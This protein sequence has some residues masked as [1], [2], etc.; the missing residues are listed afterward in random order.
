MYNNRRFQMFSCRFEEYPF[1]TNKNLP[2]VTSRRT[3]IIVIAFPSGMSDPMV[4][5][6]NKCRGV[7]Q[8]PHAI[9][10]PLTNVVLAILVPPIGAMLCKGWVVVP[11]FCIGSTGS[12]FGIR[13]SCVVLDNSF[14]SAV[15]GRDHVKRTSLCFTA[16]KSQLRKGQVCP[17]LIHGTDWES[18]T[19]AF[20][21]VES[22]VWRLKGQRR[23]IILMVDDDV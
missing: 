19:V 12:W 2:E 13:L 3:N 23:R 5:A 1:L 7:I 18:H 11:Q 10:P 17:Q 9:M 16:V 8:F 15:S 6:S 14:A 4:R 20:I 22:A 21:A